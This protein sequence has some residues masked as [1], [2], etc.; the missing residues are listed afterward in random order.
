MVDEELRKQYKETANSLKVCFYKT[1]MYKVCI[2]ILSWL[3]NKI[4]NIQVR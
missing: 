2:R 3:A 1:Y 4:E